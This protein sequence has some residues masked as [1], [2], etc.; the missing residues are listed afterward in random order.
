[1]FLLISQGMTHESWW[2]KYLA[3]WYLWVR[4]IPCR[5]IFSCVLTIHLDNFDS[6]SAPP[7]S[8]QAA[9]SF[10]LIFTTKHTLK[11][12]E[13]PLQWCSCLLLMQSV[14]MRQYKPTYKFE[15]VT[16]DIWCPLRQI[17]QVSVH[18]QSDFPAAPKWLELNHLTKNLKHIILEKR[19]AMKWIGSNVN[20]NK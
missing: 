11:R 2:K 7:L 3:G 8:V 19:V 10:P 4:T 20:K 18:F 17:F 14:S 15:T 1:M 6:T 13:V 12:L 5:C 9:V 16:A